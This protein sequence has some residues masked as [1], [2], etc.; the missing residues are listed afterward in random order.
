LKLSVALTYYLAVRSCG[1][2]C[3]HYG[4]ERDMGDLEAIAKASESQP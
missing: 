2:T 1:F 3:F 4:K